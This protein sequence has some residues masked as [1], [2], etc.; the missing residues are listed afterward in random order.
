MKITAYMVRSWIKEF[1]DNKKQTRYRIACGE[2]VI[3]LI[4]RGIRDAPDEAM[5]VDTDYEEA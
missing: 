5:L 1:R 3:S 4:E 2:K